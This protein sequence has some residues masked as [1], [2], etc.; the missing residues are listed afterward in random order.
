MYC[1]KRVV[2]I[3][4]DADRTKIRLG[5]STKYPYKYCKN[6]VN[7]FL[8]KYARATKIWEHDNHI[9]PGNGRQILIQYLEKDQIAWNAAK[10]S[11]KCIH[12]SPRRRTEGP[13]DRILGQGDISVHATRL[14]FD[15]DAP[16]EQW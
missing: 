12:N 9:K 2:S 13:W 6:I 14:L 5:M 4:A 11:I 10:K 16:G 7:N 1:G 3:G 15:V 8:G